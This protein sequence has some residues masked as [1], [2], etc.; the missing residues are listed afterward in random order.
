MFK[1]IILFFI[2]GLFFALFKV[3]FASV[4]INEV[5][6]SP[7]DERFIELYN[8][9][10]QEVNLTGFYLQR[11]T[12]SS[13]SFSSLVTST[14]FENKKISAK[15]YF[16]ISRAS[17]SNADIVLST[18][19]LTE[20]NTIQLKNSNGEV[21]DKICFGEAIDCNDALKGNNPEE[22][23]SLSRINGSLL[24]TTKTPK[25][26][27][28][29][30]DNIQ[31]DNT[32][33]E[34]T[35]TGNQNN[36]T[37]IE[38]NNPVAS[39]ISIKKNPEKLQINSQKIAFTGI[40]ILLEAVI[41]NEEYKNIYGKF[42]WNFG[43]GNFKEIKSLEN[44]KFSY[45]YFYPGKYSVFL[46][47][48]KNTFDIQAFLSSEIIIEVI[49]PSVVISNTGGE[50]N[51][52]IELEN[53][54]KNDI[55]LTNFI[56]S[57]E[58]KNFVFPKNTFLK[59]DSKIILPP[60]I[61]NLNFS[62]KN[63]LELKNDLGKVIFS[64]KI[65]ENKK[66]QSIS[67]NKISTKNLNQNILESEENFSSEE[68]M[69]SYDLVDNQALVLDSEPAEN[70][71]YNNFYFLGVLFLI[72]LGVLFVFFIRKNNTLESSV[73]EDFEILDE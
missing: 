20:S 59:K 8:G 3:S 56:L 32:Q 43:D 55:D 62:D 7:T 27:N 24:V 28:Q 51:F 18:L 67:S 71:L 14:N 34:N 5:L 21:V 73:N 41:L 30:S 4:L 37:Q 22:G 26:S 13:T 6:I 39:S 44:N 15:G 61:T 49:E 45:T 17:L 31:N 70:F 23:K 47:Y 57:G 60:H 46:E 33:T 65:L 72:F 25:A 2:F 12:Q 35:N 63:F 48:Y 54:S 53:K 42:L 40:P 19:T 1:K 68:V 11:K 58:N 50:N 10:D 16:L 66:I 52:F 9:G 38:N 64:N 69:D 36:T 29:N